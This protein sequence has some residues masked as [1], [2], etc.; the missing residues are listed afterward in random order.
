MVQYNL[1]TKS[2]SFKHLNAYERG[3]IAALYR[4][5]KSISCIAR[6]LDRAPS[7]ISRQ[8]KRGTVTQLKFDLFTYDEE[9][10]CCQD[11]V[12]FSRYTSEL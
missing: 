5:G 3:E 9:I 4:E 7:T 11:R 6:Q 12:V 8:I 1:T 10:L 2:C